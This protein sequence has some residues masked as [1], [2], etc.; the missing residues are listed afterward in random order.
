MAEWL[1]AGWLFAVGAIFGSYAVATVWRLRAR[2][3]ASC[4]IDQLNSKTKLEY[5][6]L[7]QKSALNNQ[8][9]KS[10]KSKCLHCQH[11]LTWY[12]LVPV[13]SWL[14]LCGKCR[15]CGRKIGWTEFL[16]E[17]ALGVLFAASYLLL[18]EKFGYFGLGL[19]LVLLVVLAILLIYDARWQLLPTKVLWLGMGLA[20]VFAGV[21][22][23]REFGAGVS[24][25]SLAVNY[26]MSLLV[27][28]GLYFGL[29]AISNQAW[30]GGGDGYIGVIMALVIG[31]LWLAM[32]ALFLANFLGC[33]VVFIK[34]FAQ[35]KPIRG[36]KLAFG[37]MLILALLIV[38][39]CQ[40]Q[41]LE[42][43][44]AFLVDIY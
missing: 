8:K 36:T 44:S 24:V 5:K 10:D 25:S 6:K 2:E 12:D 16:T 41:I 29:A 1:T 38:I 19:W 39:F 37:P 30:V 14:M 9:F 15:Y 11:Q 28:G 13:V 22:I 7:V 21:M 31:N 26:L 35:K 20:A 27:L 42:N 40:S 43:F 34:S 3:L 23:V 17:A 4:K 18:S 33:M 32:V